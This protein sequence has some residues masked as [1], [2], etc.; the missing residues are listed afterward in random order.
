MSSISS[1]P[2]ISKKVVEPSGYIQ[3]SNK[4]E[5]KL[6]KV[7]IINAESYPECE[8]NDKNKPIPESVFSPRMKQNKRPAGMLSQSIEK[9]QE[10]KGA[11]NFTDFLSKVDKFQKNKNEKINVLLALKK[12]QEDNEIKTIPKA[13]MSEKSKKILEDKKKKAEGPS[14]A[15]GISKPSQF[16]PSPQVPKG[17]A[18][19]KSQSNS[20][21]NLISKPLFENQIK[22]IVDTENSSSSSLNK[23]KPQ[24][25][26]KESLG[27]QDKVQASK[28]VREFNKKFDEVSL[29]KI[30]LDI[31]E[32]RKLLKVMLFLSESTESPLKKDNEEKLFMKFW[33]ITGAEEVQEISFDNIRTF[34]MGVMNFFLASMSHGDDTIGFGRVIS[35]KYYLNQDEVLRIHKYFLPFYDNRMAGLKMSAKNQQK[36]KTK[37]EK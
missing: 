11:K 27:Q 29:G 30:T 13:K 19:N 32:A 16:T 8:D 35:G 17:I 36:S 28:F 34:L 22:S 2:G 31:D 21:K 12:E 6:G 9:I 25:I 7:T 15:I 24:A 18:N 3:N 5:G 23:S 14:D 20:T 1:I 33:K 4:L 37:F 10:P 26:V